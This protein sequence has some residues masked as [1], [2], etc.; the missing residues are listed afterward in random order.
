MRRDDVVANPLHE[1][2]RVIDPQTGQVDT[3]DWRG[4]PCPYCSVWTPEVL[5]AHEEAIRDESATDASA[6]V[7]VASP[8]RE[9]DDQQSTV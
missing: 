2:H 9:R 5:R 4:C 3:T 6:R 8:T 1:Y 7:D